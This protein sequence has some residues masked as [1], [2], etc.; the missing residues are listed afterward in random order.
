L[1]FSGICTG[2]GR[3]K[4]GKFRKVVKLMKDTLNREIS[5]LRV[6]VTDR[7]NLRCRYCMPEHGVPPK[8]HDDILSYEDMLFVIKQCVSFG[9]SRIR[10]TGGEPLVRKGII[11]FISQL[12]NIE[13]IKE[14]NLTTNGI[15]LAKYAVQLKEAGIN[16]INISLDSLK[17]DRYRYITRCGSLRD[18]LDGMYEALRVGF[19]SVKVNVV[20][21]KGFNDDEIQD[22]V[23]LTRDHPLYVRFIELMPIG[24]AADWQKQYISSYEI[25]YMLSDLKEAGT[26]F[27]NGPAKYYTIDGYKGFI[28]FI[29]PVS[30]C[31]CDKCNRIR[32]TADG[33]LIPCLHSGKEV[34][35]RPLIEKGDAEAVD[36][37]IEATIKLKPKSHNIERICDRTGKSESER[38]MSQVGG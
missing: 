11:N 8:T 21:M 33:K 37:A 31:F 34:D 32:L 24:E 16:N 10:L 30:S 2:K 20:A 27:G 25:Q 28:G 38:Y 36:R 7:C 12:R 5:Y 9:I 3:K 29:D 19:D 15:Y 22:F 1:S 6:S 17:E 23:N 35:L 4:F 26:N 14:I 18:A 13:G